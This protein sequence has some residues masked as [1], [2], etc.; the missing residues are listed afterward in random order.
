MNLNK[1]EHPR[2]AKVKTHAK[3]LWQKREK[4][5]NTPLKMKE[6]LENI[7]KND[8]QFSTETYYLKTRNV[9]KII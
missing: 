2:S 7:W 5:I 1:N 4:Q 3:L 9:W 6:K 8:K